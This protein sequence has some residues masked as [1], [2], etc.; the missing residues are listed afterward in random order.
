MHGVAV[1]VPDICRLFPCP[2]GRDTADWAT[3]DGVCLHR[4]GAH[5]TEIERTAIILLTIVQ[6]FGFLLKMCGLSFLHA[7][8][9]PL[10]SGSAVTSPH[11]PHPL[12]SILAR[13]FAA[14][15]MATHHYS[16]KVF[17]YWILDRPRGGILSGHILCVPPRL[18]EGRVMGGAPH[19]WL[20][21][22]REGR[23]GFVCAIAVCVTPIPP[24]LNCVWWVA[25]TDQCASV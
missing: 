24:S 22:G 8:A 9:V 20:A 17:G 19:P 21:A 12:D 14:V 3:E 6:S 10:H 23:E 1:R 13:V 2:Q 7:E 4:N 25:I 16:E 15:A 5:C 18:A 11:L